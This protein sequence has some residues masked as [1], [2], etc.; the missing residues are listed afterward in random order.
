MP[1]VARKLPL[2]AVGGRFG[3]R[4]L[5]G[6]TASPHNATEPKQE[7]HSDERGVEGSRAV[8]SS[9]GRSPACAATA[10]TAAWLERGWSTRSAV[11]CS[12]RVGSEN[13]QINLKEVVHHVT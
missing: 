6:A 4:V 7:E 13:F 10:M 12:R 9:P 8:G 3:D 2:A 11:T 5:S 1:F